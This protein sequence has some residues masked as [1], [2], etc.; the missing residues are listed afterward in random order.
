MNNIWQLQDVVRRLQE[1]IEAALRNGPQ[2]IDCGNDAV[3][4]LSV[5]DYEAITNGSEGLVEFFQNSPLKGADLDLS[6]SASQAKA[7]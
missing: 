3:V 7:A 6:R 5:K 2:T 4:V 1:L